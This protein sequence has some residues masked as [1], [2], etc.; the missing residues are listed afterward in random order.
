M[1]VFD[2]GSAHAF[3]LRRHSAPN[4]MNRL[5]PAVIISIKSKLLVLGAVNTTVNDQGGQHV[6]R[7]L[8]SVRVLLNKQVVLPTFVKSHSAVKKTIAT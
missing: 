7:R 5:T 1:I 6:T 2:N 4:E 3:L 8:E